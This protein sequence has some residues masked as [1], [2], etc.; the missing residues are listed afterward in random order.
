MYTHICINV[1]VCYLY[2]DVR[3]SEPLKPHC[4]GTPAPSMYA[5][6]SCSCAL[7]LPL[8]ARSRNLAWGLGIRVLGYGVRV[9][10]YI[11]KQAFLF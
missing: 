6:P 3:I 5:S 10:N 9:Q 7:A 1:Y 8:I 11:R 2:I 4:R